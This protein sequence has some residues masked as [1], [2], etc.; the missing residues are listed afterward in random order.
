MTK[1]KK[2]RLFKIDPFTVMR[3]IVHR[4]MDDKDC[5]DFEKV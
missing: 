4:Y 3:N 5:F 2:L 1:L